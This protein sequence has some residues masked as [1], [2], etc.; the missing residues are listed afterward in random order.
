MISEYENRVKRLLATKP[1]PYVVGC[2]HGLYADYEIDEPEEEYLYKI[3]DPNELFN[4]PCE[5]DW[6]IIGANP[7]QKEIDEDE[8]YEQAFFE[9]IE[10]N[11][12]ICDSNP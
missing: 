3:A 11:R 7:L 1:I 2:I 12:A 4:S 6:A 9:S 5:Y 8:D 10:H